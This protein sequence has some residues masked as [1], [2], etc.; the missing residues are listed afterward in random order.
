MARWPLAIAVLPLG[1]CAH[2]GGA[3]EHYGAFASEL[4][5]RSLATTFNC[6]MATFKSEY[7]DHRR[8][9]VPVGSSFCHVLGRYGDPEY[10]GRNDVLT[11]GVARV[12]YR[13]GRKYYVVTSSRRDNGNWVVT[14]SAMTSR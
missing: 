10:V 9:V 1:A 3:P 2:F 8:Q 4:E 5:A 14:S 6:D 11:T 12:R 7:A 13:V